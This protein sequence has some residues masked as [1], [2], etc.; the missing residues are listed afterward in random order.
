MLWALSFLVTLFTFGG[1]ILMVLAFV[2]SHAAGPGFVLFFILSAIGGL[3]ATVGL[4]AGM[5]VLAI[6]SAPAS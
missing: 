6:R 3:I 2:A 5:I 1:I 4:S